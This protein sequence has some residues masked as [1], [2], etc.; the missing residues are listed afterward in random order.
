MPRHAGRFGRVMMSTTAG[1]NAITVVSLNAWDL[2]A[3]ADRFD[4]TSFFDNNKTYVIGLRDRQGSFGGF[5]DDTESQMWTGADSADGVKLYLYPDFTNN[6]ADYGYGL[7]WV[8]VS[9]A[10]PVNGAVTTQAQWAAAA[11]FDISRLSG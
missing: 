6:V 7:A 8:D 4:V 5:W 10:V 1:G 3:N 9:I 11:A 2:N